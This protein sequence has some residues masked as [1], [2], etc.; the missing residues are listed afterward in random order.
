MIGLYAVLPHI[1]AIVLLWIAVIVI[2][3]IVKQSALRTAN[4]LEIEQTPDEQ[5][6]RRRMA[7]RITS[8]VNTVAT[9]GAVIF[10]IVVLLFLYNPSERSDRDMRKIQNAPIDQGF[11][12]PSKEAI[13]VLNEEV[14]QQ[15]SAEKEEEAKKDN[16]KALGDADRLFNTK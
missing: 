8:I 7:V 1:V 9:A 15:K 2:T 14:L 4:N 13:G 12:Q 6:H 10:L 5:G 16:S 11:T 3:S